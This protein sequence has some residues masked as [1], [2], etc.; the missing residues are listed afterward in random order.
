MLIHILTGNRLD[1]MEVLEHIITQLVA[2]II[3]EE[4]EVLVVLVIQA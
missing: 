1:I 2:I 3:L 4:V